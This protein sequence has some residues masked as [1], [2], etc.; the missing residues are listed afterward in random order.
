MT[1]T[2]ALTLAGVLVA[3]GAHLSISRQAPIVPPSWGYLWA[4]WEAG[5]PSLLAASWVW[6]AYAPAL[7]AVSAAFALLV[8]AAAVVMAWVARGALASH[9]DDATAGRA[10]LRSGRRGWSTDLDSLERG[11]R[12]RHTRTPEA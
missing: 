3:A 7:H 4:T 8:G 9:L 11:L 6:P 12:A 10:V 2:L 1:P 5:V